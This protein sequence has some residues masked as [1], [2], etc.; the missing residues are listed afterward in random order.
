M[1]Q[2]ERD[3]TGGK[4]RAG[5]RS[6]VNPDALAGLKKRAEDLGLIVHAR[7]AASSSRRAP[8]RKKDNKK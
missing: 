8:S 1:K 4:S 7:D 5:V 2:S 3:K 6:I